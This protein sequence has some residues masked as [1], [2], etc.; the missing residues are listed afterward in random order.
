MA[1]PEKL[2]NYIQLTADTSAAIEEDQPATDATDFVTLSA[3]SVEEAFDEQNKTE[4]PVVVK[5]DTAEQE[6][7]EKYDPKMR[8]LAPKLHAQP[9]TL[10]K[11]K[12]VE[13]VAQVVENKDGDIEKESV[14]IRRLYDKDQKVPK[15]V[16]SKDEKSR[17]NE[18]DPNW[19][20]NITVGD[21]ELR[22]ITHY[23][24]TEETL[25]FPMEKY[26]K[27]WVDPAEEDAPKD[28][29]KK[30]KKGKPPTPPRKVFIA[31][32]IKRVSAVDN[33]AETFR[34]RFHIYFNWLPTEEDYKSHYKAKTEAKKQNKP[35]ILT[36]WEP[37]W[38]PHL[39][40]QNMIEEHTKEWELYP[41]EGFFR[42]Q[43][44]K[45]FG[46]KK[47]AE[48]PETEFDSEKARFIRAKLEC[49][50][51]FAEELELQSFPFDCQDLSCVIHERTTGG[52][53][54]IF[55]PE[56]RKPNFASVDPRYSVIDEWDL[57]TAVIEFGDADPNASR[58]KSSYAMIVLRLK[59]K[60]RWKVFFANIVFLMCCIS[61]LALTAFS[62][63]ADDLGDRLNLL[64]TLILTAVAFSYVVFDSLP[65]V[66]YLT[67]M[68]KYILGNYAFLVALMVW[69]SFMRQDWFTEIMDVWAMYASI[70]GLFLY[71]LGFG[72]YG[73]FLRRDEIQK[74]AFSSDQVEEEVNLSRPALRFDYTK[75]QRS[76]KNGRLLSFIGYTVAS[77]YMDEKQKAV[78]TKKQS[79]LDKLY[80]QQA[81]IHG[82]DAS[83][84]PTSPSMLAV[85]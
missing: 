5:K 73:T 45:D 81:S 30:K 54:C 21:L 34:M 28:D 79:E 1:D 26:P 33:I 8:D 16:H 23:D 22:K 74:L 62:L 50:M 10:D 29:K 49:E 7:E 60:R 25:W 56:L 32:K 67:F 35:Q 71:N 44:F 37:K 13:M 9:G 31:M 83:E 69:S 4:S 20:Y 3:E 75:R 17:L 2:D 27:D 85:K 53:R 51:T 24:G 58:S 64:I 63:G 47:G 46:K 15:V 52:V 72:V 39:E 6:E 84:I 40:F 76:G 61:L 57:E 18:V 43:T 11:E 55:L 19:K 48:I 78:L 80:T 12:R 38:Y 65:N 82:Y 68:D 36:D 42:I 77:Q 70:I 66:P 14:L 59:V 41:E